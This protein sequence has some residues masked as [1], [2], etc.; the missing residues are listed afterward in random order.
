MTISHLCR[1]PF[2][3]MILGRICLRFVPDQKSALRRLSK[4]RRLKMARKSQLG[5]QIITPE[6]KESWQTKSQKAADI[7]RGCPALACR[8]SLLHFQCESG[9]ELNFCMK[10]SPPPDEPG[11]SSPPRP[12]SGGFRGV[13]HSGR[14]PPCPRN[15]PT[16]T[17][18]RAG[19]TAPIRQAT[20]SA[21]G[22]FLSRFRFSP[23]A[24]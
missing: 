22:H 13:N 12:F 1:H 19:I 3:Q 21:L 10:S 7:H 2:R 18:F 23:V 9:G 14:Y 24:R 11:A 8:F 16:A 5:F 15:C 20:A 17:R 4:L 6:P